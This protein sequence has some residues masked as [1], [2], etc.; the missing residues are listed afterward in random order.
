MKKGLDLEN[1]KLARLI[2]QEPC[3]DD[4]K[5]EELTMGQMPLKVHASPG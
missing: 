4:R 5:L 2:L 1:S 3:A